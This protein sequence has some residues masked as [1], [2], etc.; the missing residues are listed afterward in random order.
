[1]TSVLPIDITRCLGEGH[2]G[3]VCVMRQD[4]LRY[5]DRNRPDSDKPLSFAMMLC[6][7][8][9]RRYDYQIPL[10]GESPCTSAKL[11]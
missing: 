2:A 6:N 1:M 5:L 3:H 4:C 8:L 11:N 10:K 9:T 7:D